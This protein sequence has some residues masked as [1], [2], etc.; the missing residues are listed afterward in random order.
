M[1]DCRLTV[2]FVDR[3][4]I[5]IVIDAYEKQAFSESEFVRDFRKEL[6]K[7]NALA[8]E[9]MPKNVVT[10]HSTFR[11][12]NLVTDEEKVITLLFPDEM[13]PWHTPRHSGVSILSPLGSA[14]FGRTVGDVIDRPAK[15]RVEEILYQPEAAGEYVH[16]G[17]GHGYAGISHP[18]GR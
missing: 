9:N 6:K 1:K 4:R 7:A 10:L 13:R 16:K 2:T 11:V 15:T 12:R 8:P 17:A 18:L 14:L 5:L 3:N